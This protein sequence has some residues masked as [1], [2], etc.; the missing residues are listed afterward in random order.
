MG[1]LR[2]CI[3][4][5]GD[6]PENPEV[7]NACNDFFDVMPLAA[8]VNESALCLHGGIGSSI[9]SLSDIESIK[10]PLEVIHEVTN[11]EQQFIVDIL[12]SD[13]TESDT[14][15]GL[16]PN[17]ERDRTGI[18]NITKFGPDRVIEF[19]KNNNL[20][21]ILR[22][23]ECVMDGF[24]RF[25]GGKLITIFS[26]TDYMGRYKNAGAVVFLTNKFE[27]KPYLIYPQ[28]NPCNNWDNSE[29]SLKLRPPT[30]PRSRT[31][32]KAKKLSFD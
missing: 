14:M 29:E 30:P 2:E 8:L 4:R 9:T 1:F 7:F 5:I 6:D 28:D 19:L 13:P 16:Y 32:D 15:L 31:N 3:M 18:G 12:W 10:R 11:T 24:E 27:I 22:A 17:V 21:L 26:A 23:H 20:S 25:A